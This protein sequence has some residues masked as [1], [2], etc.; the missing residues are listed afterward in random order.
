MKLAGTK[1]LVVGMKKSGI[2][3]VELL[4]RHGAVVHATD[5][6]PLDQLPEAAE[7]LARLKIPFAQ[8]TAEVFEGCDLIVLSP[9][10]PADLTLVE[11]A[12]QQGARVVGEVELAAPFLKGETIGITGSN[13]KTT[14]TSLIGHIL[15]EAGAPVQVGG[16]I[17]K[18][19]T[20]M[21][22]S[23]QAGGWN[24][25]ELSSFQLET[26]SEFRAHIGLALNV[27]QNHLD[28]HHTFERYAAAKGRL[29]ETQRSGDFAVLN[30]ED[31]VCVEYGR[32][33]AAT[34]Q[35]FSSEREVSPGAYLR[36]S[37]LMLDASLLMDAS[38]IPIRG[39]HNVENVLAA[40]IA[41]ARAGVKPEVIAGAV[42]TFHAVEHRLE[43]VRS[44][45][46][47]DFY[48]DSKAT[49]V[50]ATLKAVNAFPGG[51]WVILGGKDKGLD[52]SLLREPL[53]AKARAALLIGAAAKKI[54][55]QL[56]GAV[57]LVDAKTLDAAVTKAYR[58]AQPGD[59]VL[60]AP[61]CASFDQFK[62]FEHRGEVFKQIVNQL[63]PKE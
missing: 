4:V 33:T 35:W 61:A 54:G 22:D 49:S 20:A 46:G 34:P 55:E 51:L 13:G 37:C 58:D 47:I 25:L 18:P 43:F 62:S 12:R 32:R 2:A 17:G 38:E 16:N 57:S 48:N 7:L 36:G 44:L 27:T 11:A 3:S 5:L 1:T 19:V 23:S 59:T 26:I 8:Q 6:K 24:V 52:Y 14:T 39:R 10:V 41:A 50:D 9:D 42:R 45:N 31:P 30:A 63:R 56:K 53:A 29:F 40:S 60:L 28:R 21:I 15:H